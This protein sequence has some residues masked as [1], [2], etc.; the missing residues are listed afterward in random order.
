MKNN[1]LKQPEYNK[2]NFIDFTNPHLWLSS[3][4]SSKSGHPKF[5]YV[6]AAICIAL[7][8]IVTA[9]IKFKGGL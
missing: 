7:I 3:V 2:A 9:V 8:V 4:K 6:Q 5:P 1:K